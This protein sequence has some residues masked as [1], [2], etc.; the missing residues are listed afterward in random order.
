MQLSIL[1]HV[2][3]PQKFPWRKEYLFAFTFSAKML[4]LANF[5]IVL[6]VEKAFFSPQIPFKGKHFILR[7]VT[8]A[9]TVIQYCFRSIHF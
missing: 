5:L 2:D 3:K 4:S 9:D 1:C 7:S 8:I 6:N